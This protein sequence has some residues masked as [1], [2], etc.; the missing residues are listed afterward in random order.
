MEEGIEKHAPTRS[1]QIDSL[2]R[3]CSLVGNLMSKDTV[4]SIART[5]PTHTS[6][7]IHSY[8]CV[9]SHT[10]MYAFTHFHVSMHTHTLVEMQLETSDQLK[11]GV[12][13]KIGEAM[14]SSPF[15]VPLVELGCW[16]FSL[17]ETTPEPVSPR[18]PH[19]FLCD[20]DNDDMARHADIETHADVGRHGDVKRHGD[21]Q[22]QQRRNSHIDLLEINFDSVSL[23]PKHAAIP[24]RSTSDVHVSS[25]SPGAM[26]GDGDG[27]S[28]D[29]DDVSG[30]GTLGERTRSKEILRALESFMVLYDLGCQGENESRLNLAQNIEQMGA[31]GCVSGSCIKS[32]PSASMHKMEEERMSRSSQSCLPRATL[33]ALRRSSVVM[34]IAAAFARVAARDGT[35][36]SVAVSSLRKLQTATVDFS[37]SVY[38]QQ[39]LLALQYSPDVLLFTTAPPAPQQPRPLGDTEIKE[40]SWPTDFAPLKDLEATHMKTEPNSHSNTHTKHGDGDMRHADMRDGDIRDGDILGMK[41]CDVMEGGMRTAATSIERPADVDS[42]VPPSASSSPPKKSYEDLLL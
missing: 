38:I 19:F 28:G 40:F 29:G 15:Q 4:R 35:C 10:L 5:V 9:H 22:R 16:L 41:E 8:T 20:D 34:L 23:T 12:L 3:L 18:D 36:M 39:M 32:Y 27:V 21:I 37:A 24:D 14:K 31:G 30:D 7:S 25:G 11:D 2:I 33:T 26:L 1:W 17:Y 13:Y 6:L 42:N